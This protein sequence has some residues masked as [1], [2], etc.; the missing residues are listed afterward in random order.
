VADELLKKFRSYAK[1]RTANVEDLDAVD[2][3][4]PMRANTIR[5]YLDRLEEVGLRRS[6]WNHDSLIPVSDTIHHSDHI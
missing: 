1:L 6:R 3:V 4:G 5:A 2:G